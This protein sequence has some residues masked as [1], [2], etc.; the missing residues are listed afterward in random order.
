MEVY[1]ARLDEA[2]GKKADEAWLDEI[3]DKESLAYAFAREAQAR[4][5]AHYA[6]ENPKVV[7]S[8]TPE[9]LRPL[10]Y[11]GAALGMQDSMRSRDDELT[12]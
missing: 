4:H 9:N 3:G 5:N 11:V 12:R 8:W 6:G 1:L 7:D 2:K 10:G